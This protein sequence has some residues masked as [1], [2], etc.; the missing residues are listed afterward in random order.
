MGYRSHD[1]VIHIRL[2]CDGGAESIDFRDAFDL[3]ENVLYASDRRDIEYAS[4]SL[5][6]H[7]IIADAAKERIRN[8][9]H[10]RLRITEV[11]T[12]SIILEGTIVAV[13][14]FVL[15]KTI[16]EPIGEAYKKSMP[17]KELS[18]FFRYLIDEKTI[19]ISEKLRKISYAR[20]YMS[21]VRHEI[22][23]PDSPRHIYLDLKREEGHKRPRIPSLGEELDKKE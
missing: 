11:S 13:A 1:I 21:D 17:Y 9:R 18:D 3:I 7:S 10:E 15:K 6:I 23:S 14:L 4:Q 2:S 12:G 5:Q 8:L 20:G 19:F 16:G 22:K